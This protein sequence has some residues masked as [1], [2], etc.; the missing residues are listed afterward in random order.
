MSKPKQSAV[1]SQW[2]YCYYNRLCGMVKGHPQIKDGSEIVTSA[3]E[4]IDES[5]GIAITTNTIY[6]LE[7]KREDL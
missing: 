6:S 2:Y 7:N 3:I 4:D 1:L 5:R